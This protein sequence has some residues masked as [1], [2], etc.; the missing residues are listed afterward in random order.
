[1]ELQI[2]HT[3]TYRGVPVILRDLEDGKAYIFAW[4]VG[5]KWVDEDKLED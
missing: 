1:M 4:D 2:G 3:Y 5:Y